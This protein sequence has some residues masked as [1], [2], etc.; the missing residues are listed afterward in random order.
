[1][2]IMKTTGVHT[3]PHSTLILYICVKNGTVI[4][5]NSQAFKIHSR[6]WAVLL[7]VEAEGGDAGVMEVEMKEMQRVQ[8]VE[9][10]S[11]G[12]KT[13]RECMGSKE[14]GR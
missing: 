9:T 4:Q 2:Q 6:G 1:M 12:G 14:E 13:L 11:K 10:E 7:S 3:S 8:S 5:K